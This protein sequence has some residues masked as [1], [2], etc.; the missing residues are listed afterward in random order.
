M[1]H[2]LSIINLSEEELLSWE[3]FRCQ[4]LYFLSRLS[5][6]A[7]ALMPAL[8]LI[9]KSE[10]YLDKTATNPCEMCKTEGSNGEV[11]SSHHREAIRRRGMFIV[12]RTTTT[13]LLP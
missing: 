11:D 2:Y 4:T 5:Q 9:I 10:L 1:F 6:R 7:L 12:H 13:F 3:A 8:L